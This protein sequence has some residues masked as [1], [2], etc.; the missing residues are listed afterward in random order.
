MAIVA[1][2]DCRKDISDAAPSCPN[3]GRPG[4]I[5]ASARG[6]QIPHAQPVR[7]VGLLLAL[8]ILLLPMVFAWFTLSR[9]RTTKARVMAFGYLALSVWLFASQQSHDATSKPDSS[10]ASAPKAAAPA[11]EEVMPLAVGQILSDYKN[12]E[13]AADNRFK[14]RLV[15][16]TG[17]VGDIK[18]DI[19]NSLYVTIGT[20]AAFELPMA[21]AFFDDSMSQQLGQLRKGQKITATCRVKGLMMNVLLEDCEMK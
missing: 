11:Q 16:I 19:T 2:P 1:C 6:A 20:G 4:A 5:A 8:G 15:R 18:K 14:G 3:C 17:T 21:Q 7:P 10:V 9:G 13:V 12:N